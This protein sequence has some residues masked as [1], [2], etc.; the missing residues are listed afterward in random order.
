MAGFS[1]YIGIVHKRPTPETVWAF[2]M[3]SLAPP[4]KSLACH[5]GY[6]EGWPIGVAG[7]Q[8]S[9]AR[10]SSGWLITGGAWFDSKWNH[11]GESPDFSLIVIYRHPVKC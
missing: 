9:I 6:W 2:V 5:A 1:C 11:Q 3:H 8:G 7:Q 10:R 4:H